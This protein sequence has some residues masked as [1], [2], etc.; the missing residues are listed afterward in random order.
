L[1]VEWAHALATNASIILSVAKSA[2]DSDLLAAIAAATNAGA[3]VVSMSWGGTEWSGETAYDRYFQTPGVTYVASSGDS[4]ELSSQ[5]EVEWPAVS[6]YV[7]GVGGTSLYLDANGNRTSPETAWTSS[8][9]G[10]STVYGLPLWLNSWFPQWPAKRGV[11]DVSLVAD[12]NT[13]V[14]VYCSTYKPSGSGWYQV[15]GTSASAPMWAALIALANQPRSAAGTLTSANATLYSLAQ[16]APTPYSINSTYF[17]DVASGANGTD[18]DDISGPG[19]DLVTGLGTPVASALV[20]AL[21]GFKPDFSLSVNP[22]SQPVAAGGISANY[23]VTVTPANGFTATVTLNASGL[24]AGSTYSFNPASVSGS[25]S[26]SLSVTTPGG[27]VAGVYPFTIT[28]TSGSLGH[29]AS[30]TLV[31]GPP[32][33]PTQISPSG[34]GQ[35]PMPTYSFHTVPGA[36]GYVIDIVPTTG[37]DIMTR[38]YTAAEVDP[39]NTGTGTITLTTPLGAGGWRWFVLALNASG[40]GPWSPPMYFTVP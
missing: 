25:G 12:P 13:G 24:P 39:G 1:D 38:V 16:V 32:P 23:T 11:P 9:G 3:T 20:P 40:W 14:Y 33:A 4:G 36:T 7:L 29:T 27:T 18:P 5:P 10:L 35:S 30:A 6:P 26:S 2:S 28:G 21:A 31:V 8:G 17:F 22:T 19:Y 37:P 34:G 15:G